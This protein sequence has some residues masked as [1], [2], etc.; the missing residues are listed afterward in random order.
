MVTTV[1][2]ALL[3]RKILR[4][5]FFFF[6]SFLGVVLLTILVQTPRKKCPLH[7]PPSGMALTPPPTPI[8]LTRREYV[9]CA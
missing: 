1:L 8:A 4:W 3:T 5:S 7:L 9:D 6:S 2:N